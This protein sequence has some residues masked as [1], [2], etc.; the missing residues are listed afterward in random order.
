MVNIHTFEA[1]DWG[2]N[3]IPVPE[4]KLITPKTNKREE[5]QEISPDLARNIME[6]NEKGR[7]FGQDE[8]EKTFG[9]KI[10]NIPPIPFT[11]HELELARDNGQYLIL[12]SDKLSDGTSLTM[13]N[14]NSMLAGKLNIGPDYKIL[15]KVDW[16]ANE[17]FYKKETPKLSWSLATKESIPNTK[18]KNYLDQTELLL[19]YA[20]SVAE[21]NTP[22]KL[23][24]DEA[25]AEWNQIKPQ[26]AALITDTNKWKETADLLAPLKITKLFRHTPVEVIYDILVRLQNNPDDT[27]A[28]SEYIWTSGRSSVGN[29]V[30]VGFAVAGGAG[31]HG[32]Q[33]G[34]TFSSLVA[35]FSR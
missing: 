1:E 28:K 16:Y 19:S 4:D 10:E 32:D 15:Y 25:E 33:P 34:L 17:D 31:V 21:D 20:K 13:E 14:V 26:I 6:K 2:K 18:S 30:H 3:A 22:F 29:F 27:M 7:F 23:A 5:G 8:I 11:E 35:S 24:L 12:R 9:Q